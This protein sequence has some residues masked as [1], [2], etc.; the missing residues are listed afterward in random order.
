MARGRFHH[1]MDAKGRVTIPAGYRTELMAG[2]AGPPVATGLI[3]F[4]ALGLYSQPRW[5]QIEERLAGMSES[6]PEVQSVRRL[7]I[8]SAEDCPI[9]AQGRIL[10]P[11]HLREYAGLEREVTL[12]GM[13]SR[14]EIWDKTRFEQELASVRERSQEIASVVAEAG[15]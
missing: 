6:K 1:T 13:G 5:Q 14:I 15:F 2:E 8:S 9:D 3:G 12:A 4:P 11:P 10:V 7:V